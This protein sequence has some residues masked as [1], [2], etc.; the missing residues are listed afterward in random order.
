MKTSRYVLYVGG[1][2]AVLIAAL[3]V[4]FGLRDRDS[5]AT[6]SPS[7]IPATSTPAPASSPPTTPSPVVTASPAPTA[8][9]GPPSS[10]ASVCGTVSDDV[11]STSTTN[12]SL[13]LN[14]PGRPPLK[15]TDLFL[16]SPRSPGGGIAGYIC[17]SLQ[18][19]VPN[20]I[21]GGL[22]TPNTAGFVAEGTLP[23][24]KANPPP[25]GF[26]VPQTCAYVVPPLVGG[27]QNE[28]KVDCGADANRNARG[29]LA[30]ALTQQGWTSCGVGLGTASWAKG[31]ARLF[32]AESSMSPGDYPKLTQPVR[33]AATSSC[34]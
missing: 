17:T 31:T 1:V 30:P 34:P 9:P 19:G 5:Q 3:I 4:G 14:S 8:Q 29:T 24:T 12:G 7:P 32:I 28:W 22:W 20:P 13:V 16:T 10:W 27:D 11:A 25:T 15:I 2:A 21:F 26:V 33:P 18:A 6:A 23:A